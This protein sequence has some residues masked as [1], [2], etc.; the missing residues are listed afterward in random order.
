MTKEIII[1]TSNDYS[2][3]AIKKAVTEMIVQNPFSLYSLSLGTL[4][5]TASFVLGIPVL[6]PVSGACLTCG[7]SGYAVNFLFRK[8]RIARKYIEKLNF[9]MEKYREEMLKNISKK[10]SAENFEHDLKDFA[11]QGAEQFKMIKD[12]FDNFKSILDEKFEPNEITYGRYL[13]AGEQLYLSVLDNLEK[14]ASKLKVADGIETGYIKERMKYLEELQKK[15]TMEDA[16]IKEMKTL[17][18]RHELRQKKMS[19]INE[20]LTSNEEAMTQLDKAAAVISELKT[21]TGRAKMD[22]DTAR[23]EL[24]ELLKRSNK[25]EIEE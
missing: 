3:A 2:Q 21:K 9:K 24:E 15:G 8:D 10:L 18:E 14:I 23:E 20:H 11:S 1:P 22:M 17:K 16:D 13:G 19:E 12:K 5:L 4:G 7:I 6:L 25:Y